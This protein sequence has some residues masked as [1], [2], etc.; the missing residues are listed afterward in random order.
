[1]YLDKPLALFCHHLIALARQSL[2]ANYEKIMLLIFA[3]FKMITIM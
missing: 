1:M 3:K 2:E